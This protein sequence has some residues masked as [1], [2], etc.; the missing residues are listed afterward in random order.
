MNAFMIVLTEFKSIGKVRLWPILRY[1]P[2]LS[3]GGAE[4][5]HEE[6]QD[7][8]SR[9]RIGTIPRCIISWLF[10]SHTYEEILTI[11]STTQ[12]HLLFSTSAAGFDKV[13]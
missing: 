9:S 4:E 7:G 13:D 2:H 6:P 1:C 11:P 10:A 12:P 3:S 8:R 5:K